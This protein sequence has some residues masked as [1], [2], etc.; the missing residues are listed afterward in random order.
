LLGRAERSSWV[1]GFVN[2]AIAF[3]P[4]ACEEDSGE[5]AFAGQHGRPDGRSGNPARQPEVKELWVYLASAGA[6]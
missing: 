5:R 2:G 4:K 6:Q 1:R 3:F